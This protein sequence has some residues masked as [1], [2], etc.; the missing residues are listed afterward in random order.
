MN[1]EYLLITGASSGIGRQCAIQLSKQYNL[2]LCARRYDKLE[3]TKSICKNTQ[4]HLIF[5]YDLSDTENLET[6]LIDFIKINNIVITKFLHSAG[7]IGLQSLK[8]VDSD[9]ML[10]CLKINLVSAELIVKVLSSKRY[11]QSA[12]DSV[13]FISSNISNMGAKGFSTYSAS[14]AGLDGMMRS[15]AIE[16]APKVR[17]NSILPGGMKTEMTK[18]IDANEEVSKRLESSFP[19]GQGKPQYIAD[20]AEF[21]FSDKASWITGQQ[22]TVDGGRTINISS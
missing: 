12:L 13:V 21:L 4:N 3:E 22:L 11:N 2:I 9:F 10:N 1:K 16:L 6:A 8:L 17:I 14:K 18:D 20:A 15:L 19:L 5:P 7:T